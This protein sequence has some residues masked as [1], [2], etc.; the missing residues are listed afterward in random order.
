[1]IFLKH[2]KTHGNIYIYLLLCIYRLE[3]MTDDESIH[4]L[5][6]LVLLISS[7]TTCGY[8]EL[9]PNSIVY[10]APF[11][12]PG[13]TLPAPS[14]TGE[15][16][17]LPPRC[18]PI[19]IQW[20]EVHGNLQRMEKLGLSTHLKTHQ[21]LP[22]YI[23]PMVILVLQFLPFVILFNSSNA[24]LWQFREDTLLVI[25]IL[26]RCFMVEANK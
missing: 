14:G 15:F 5:R 2:L 23:L 3:V 25:L 19:S 18:V 21:F 13:F 12:V 10:E 20:C 26:P 22:T 11:Q 6:N 4:S 17:Y 24:L 9:R 16:E 1:M 8:Q 7:L